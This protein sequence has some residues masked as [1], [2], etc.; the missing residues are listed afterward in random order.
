VRRPGGLSLLHRIVGTLGPV[1]RIALVL[2]ALAGGLAAV[3]LLTS[4][5]ANEGERPAAA[6]PAKA[7]PFRA[8]LLPGG[9]AGRRAPPFELVDARGGTFSTRQLIGRPYLVTF[10]YTDCTD[11]CPVIGRV[12]RRALARLGTRGRE[13]AA[14][15]ISVD[16]QSDSPAAVRRWLRLQRQPKNFHYLIGSR[17]KLEPVWKSY[18]VAPQPHGIR[19]G[20][21]TANI[22][23]IDRKG[24]WRA[25]F[26]GGAPLDP[27]D[28][29]HDLR[30]LLS[31][32]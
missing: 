5:N 22:W 28:V 17:S 10:L 8:D 30:L 24:R 12:L 6:Y 32:R 31:E 25:K 3:A 1:L 2:F 15:A 9:V 13:V 29:A 21:H 4:R 19:E 26:S 11:I 16:P 18:Y 14:V 27:E 23:L 7:G 20:R